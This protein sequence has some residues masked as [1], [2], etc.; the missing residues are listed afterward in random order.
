MANALMLK[1]QGWTCLTPFRFLGDQL[2][3][4][5]MAYIC[6]LLSAIPKFSKNPFARENTARAGFL[7]TILNICL[8]DLKTPKIAGYS[9]IC[10]KIG[11]KCQTNTLQILSKRENRSY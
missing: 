10:D 2:F 5:I 3:T 1:A 6:F 11:L 4:T 8:M 9:T 7:V